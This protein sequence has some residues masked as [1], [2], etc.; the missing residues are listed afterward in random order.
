LV[1]SEG[2][3]ARVQARA[4]DRSD[5]A[6][7]AAVSALAYSPD[8]LILAVGGHDTLVNLHDASSSAA[9]AAAAAAADEGSGADV[10]PDDPAAPDNPGRA[11]TS[12]H[13]IL[14][15]MPS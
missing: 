10:L 6:E 3:T 15:I 8:G 5:V 1:S 7:N 2:A 4:V 13:V 12:H 14:P 9:A 11:G